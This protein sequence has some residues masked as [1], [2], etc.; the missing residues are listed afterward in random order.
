M[1]MPH[2]IIRTTAFLIVSFLVFLLLD[3]ITNL[4]LR[5]NL[6]MMQR[7]PQSSATRTKP[8]TAYPPSQSL[9][10]FFLKA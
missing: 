3:D 1:Q 7:I 5:E 6:Q 2:R 8:A 9:Q 10:R 4:R